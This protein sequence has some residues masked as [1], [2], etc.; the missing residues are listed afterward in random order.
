[1]RNWGGGGAGKQT[2][3]DGKNLVVSED[4]VFLADFGGFVDREDLET[5]K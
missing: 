3:V 2:L 4:V 1:M 5:G